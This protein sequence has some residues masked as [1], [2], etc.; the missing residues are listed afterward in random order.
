ML[1]KR[2]F[3][4]TPQTCELVHEALQKQFPGI[5][6]LQVYI[7]HDVSR[8]SSITVKFDFS[9]ADKNDVLQFIDKSLTY[10]R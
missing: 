9:S 10:I 6:E 5:R 4:R 8:S 7:D 1:S 2:Q 3:A